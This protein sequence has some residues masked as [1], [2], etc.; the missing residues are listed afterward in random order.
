MIF[1]CQPYWHIYC[2]P[3]IRCVIK[4]VMPRFCKGISNESEMPLT[5]GADAG[6]QFMKGG[7]Y[8]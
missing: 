2:S 7:S 3:I 6:A 4:P 1:Y 5:G 8:F